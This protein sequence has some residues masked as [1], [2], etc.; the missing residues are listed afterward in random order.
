MAK[1]LGVGGVFFKTPDFR[2]I[3]PGKHCFQIAPGLV[4]Q[5]DGACLGVLSF[6][7]ELVPRRTPDFDACTEA[8]SLLPDFIGE[9]GQQARKVFAALLVGLVQFLDRSGHGCALLEGVER[10][11]TALFPG[12]RRNQ[13][14]S[15]TRSGH[16]CLSFQ[17]TDPMIPL[18]DCSPHHDSVQPLPC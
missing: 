18:S 14:G 6:A 1:V 16:G 5:I 4:N 9:M 11:R 17:L 2:R 12:S 8:A 3:A 13:D 15:A 10:L 7:G